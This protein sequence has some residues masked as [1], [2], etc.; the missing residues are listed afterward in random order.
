MNAAVK[1]GVIL[2]VVV[3]LLSILFY[4]AGLHENPMASMVLLLVF[5]LVN[6]GVVVWSLKQTAGENP[7]GKQLLNGAVIGLVGGVLILASSF[8]LQ[9]YV[10]PNA[11]QE[12]RDATASW[13]ES[14]NMP[15]AQLDVQLKKLDAV[16]PM[17]NAIQ[18]CVGTFFTSLIGAGIAGIFL[19]KK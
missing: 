7:Y 18:G 4:V 16:T 1:A 13:L 12:S 10:F 3:A 11:I 19:R 14:M 8:V 5:I 6:L 9:S 17:K 2:A 15:E